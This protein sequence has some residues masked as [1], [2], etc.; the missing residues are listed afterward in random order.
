MILY[1]TPGQK[2]AQQEDTT[3]TQTNNMNNFGRKET[4]NAW[5]RKSRQID[6]V[7]PADRQP[8]SQAASQP[9][10]PSHAMRRGRRRRSGRSRRGTFQY[11]DSAQSAKPSLNFL[12]AP[13]FIFARSPY[14][15]LRW[16]METSSKS[17]G[18]GQQYLQPPRFSIFLFLGM[19]QKFENIF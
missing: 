5:S 4:W 19:L 12:L 14:F 15:K 6:S 2:K 9:T 17:N 18:N 1:L 13:H 16:D 10:S 8:V 7:S 3:P 11:L